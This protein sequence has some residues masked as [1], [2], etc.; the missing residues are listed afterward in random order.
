MPTTLIPILMAI[1]HI[2]VVGRGV[3]VT[4]VMGDGLIM[5][6]GVRVTGVMGDG[7]ITVLEVRVTGVMEGIADNTFF[8]KLQVNGCSLDQERPSFLF[9]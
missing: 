9:S 7:V 3:R 1:T 8:S 4:G 2:M 5:V 6:R